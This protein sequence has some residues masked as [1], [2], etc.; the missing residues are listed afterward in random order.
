MG[1]F[2]YIVAATT[3]GFSLLTLATPAISRMS[4]TTG[5]PTTTMHPTPGSASPSDSKK[6]LIPSN[7]CGAKY[8]VSPNG[9]K[10][11]ALFIFHG[12]RR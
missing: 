5:M 2:L 4:T 8:R 11:R 12:R 7:Y 9:P 6:S 10:T 3:G 1:Y